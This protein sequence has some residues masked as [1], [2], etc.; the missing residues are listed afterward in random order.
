[1]LRSVAVVGALLA[2]ACAASPALPPE[3]EPV[4]YA[5]H[6]E[7]VVLKRCLSCHTHEEAK[8]RLVL[9]QGAGYANLVGP[10][11]TQASGVPLV[12]PGDLERSYLWLK[13][14]D[15]APVGDGMPHT[16]F[17]YRRL[18]EDELEL[19]RRWIEDGARE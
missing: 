16:V 15:R 5:A 18:P 17:G 13:L 3:G 7:P 11:S 19:F 9:E 12:A 10:S 1:M 2:C 14:D 6:L 8:A 4:A